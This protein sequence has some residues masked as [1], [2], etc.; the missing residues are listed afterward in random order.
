M[1]N[2]PTMNFQGYLENSYKI[3][4]SEPFILILGGLLI[5]LLNSVTLSILYGPLFG[6]YMLMVLLLL[7]DGK[8]PVINDLF[9]GFQLFRLLFPYCFVLLAKIIGFMLFIVPGLLF[10]T[11]W[12]Y[13]LPL[14]VDRKISFG[15][16]MRISSD[17]V[18]ETGFFIHLVFILLVYVIPVILLNMLVSLM[19]F[20][21]VLTLL[22]MPFQV[23]CMISLYLDQFGAGEHVSAAP[24]EADSPVTVVSAEQLEG[25]SLQAAGAAEDKTAADESSDNT[26]NN[27]ENQ[28][29]SHDK[30]D[31]AESERREGN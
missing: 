26:G 18:S 29:G 25:A 31:D 6:G 23:G 10:S 17:K 12:I 4:K 2:T 22:L 11:W 20:L 7:R 3:I 28:A 27:H 14:M 5:Q 16:A 9:N 8:K 19:P 24:E 15:E 13:V 30:R 1:T 21:L